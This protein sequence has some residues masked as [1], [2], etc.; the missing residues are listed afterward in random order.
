MSNTENSIDMTRPLPDVQPWSRPFWE[1]AKNGEL[2]VQHC[3]DCAA[4]IFY[5]RK[6]CPECWSGNLDWIKSSGK[7]VVYSFSTAYDMVEPRFWEDLPYTI[8]FVD[9][10]EGVRMM[11]RIVECDPEDISIGMEVKV[12]W[13]K[14]N[15][16]FFLPYFRPVKS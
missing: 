5:P 1:A 2:L 3:M 7:A 4:N 15:D 8:A 11:T 13:R 9:L 14:L 6:Y 16:D 12:T 10:P